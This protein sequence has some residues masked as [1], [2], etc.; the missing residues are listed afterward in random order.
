MVGQE[1]GIVRLD[2]VGTRAFWKDPELNVAECADL[3][4]VW[5]GRHKVLGEFHD[6][7]EAQAG[8][9]MAFGT[10]WEDVMFGIYLSDGKIAT[11]TQRPGCDG[12]IVS[13]LVL[14]RITLEGKPFIGGVHLG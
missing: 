14:V 11:T 8:D 9:M 4:T 7:R 2:R 10:G 13:K 3:A 6:V 12:K 1:T 5:S